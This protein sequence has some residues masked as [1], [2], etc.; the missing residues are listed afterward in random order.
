MPTIL[1]HPAVPLA[2]GAGLGTRALPPRLLAAGVVASI[3]PDADVIGYQLGGVWGSDF[4]HRGFTHSLFFA[5]A[6]ALLGAAAWR[7]LGARPP[8]VLL[9]LFAAAASHGLLDACTNGGSGIA[10]LW[11]FSS[12]RYFAPF[13]VIEV[14]PIGV[15]RFL[16][17]R[18]L[19]VL[20]SELRW[21]WFPA[22]VLAALL[23]AAR[24][25]FAPRAPLDPG[26]RPV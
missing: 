26:D 21:V 19:Q 24:R 15:A 10:L 1:S 16:T 3:L 9:F 20:G 23:L 7:R 17:E 18:G 12:Q 22:A 2:L 13:A 5:A 8:T 14:S 25:A 11:P 4:A 6:L